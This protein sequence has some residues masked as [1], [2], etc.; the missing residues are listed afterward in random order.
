MSRHLY[1]D[2]QQ[3]TLDLQQRSEVCLAETHVHQYW[4]CA[5]KAWLLYKINLNWLI[6]KRIFSRAVIVSAY[7][8]LMFHMA[9]IM[10]QHVLMKCL[11]KHFY[12]SFYVEIF[13]YYFLSNLLYLFYS[14]TS[15]ILQA[16]KIILIPTE[17]LTNGV[18]VNGSVV[19]QQ[20]M[21]VAKLLK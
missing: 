6:I 1:S 18:L 13:L 7:I 5:S 19:F 21:V 10:T 11:G 20:L 15:N 8:K 9:E 4:Y 16:R 17:K 2:Q 12:M 3:K 14:S